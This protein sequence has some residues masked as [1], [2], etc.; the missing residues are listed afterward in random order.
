MQ[1]GDWVCGKND[2]NYSGVFLA[3][4]THIDTER[5]EISIMLYIHRTPSCSILY[6]GYHYLHKSYFCV[7]NFE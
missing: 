5:N 4:I 1:V 6:R 3:K 2:M 7:V